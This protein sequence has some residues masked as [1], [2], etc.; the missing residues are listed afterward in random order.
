MALWG[1][2]LALTACTAPDAHVPPFARV[3]YQ[4]FSRQAV[5]A[6]TLREWRLFGAHI[7]ESPIGTTHAED[8]PERDPGLWQ[9]VGEY[10]WLGLDAGSPESGWT[11]KHDGSGR[12]F[13]ASRDGRF[14]WSAAFVSY[15]MR[16]AGAGDRFP[17]APDHAAYINA[18]RR[19]GRWVM[20]AERPD[21][22]A[23]VPGDIVCRGRGWAAGLKFD[24]LPAE[25]FPSHCDIVVG[26]PA[27]G[28]I[29][30]VGGNVGDSVTL[31]YLP[32]QPDGRLEDGDPP[33]L[34]VLR[35]SGAHDAPPA[36]LTQVTTPAAEVPRIGP[37]P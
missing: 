37:V 9:R 28:M 35:L 17:Y 22:Y 25:P 20:A 3:P 24:D 8:K 16:I 32:V 10:W 29:A 23:P 7:A 6:V 1:A 19:G 11:G 36:L 15:V 21:A 12:V 18:A 31:R 34:A 26:P 33:W 13:P 14:A 5:V 2:L 27:N 30:V 4:A